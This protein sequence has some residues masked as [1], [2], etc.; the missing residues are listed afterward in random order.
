MAVGK[1]RR[2]RRGARVPE[3]VLTAALLLVGAGC[4]TRQPDSAFQ[5]LLKAEQGGSAQSSGAAGNASSAGNGTG[6]ANPSGAVSADNSSSGASAIGTGSLAGSGSAPV[7]G[8]GPSGSSTAPSSAN[9]SSSGAVRRGATDVGVSAD[10]ILVGNITSI[11]GPLGPDQFSPT[12]HGASAFFQALN[13]RGGI[14]GRK[15]KFL[16]CDDVENVDQDRQCAVN[17]IQNQKV[18]ALA[19]SNTRV[20]N[21]AASYVDSQGV[22]DVGSEAIGNAYAKYHH[23]YGIVGV[24]RYPRDGKQVGLNGNE[25]TLDGSYRWFKEKVGISRAAVFF[26]TIA[27]SRQAGLLEAA[28]LRRQG[29]SVVYY[30]GGS[31]QGENV[32]APSYDTDVINMRNDNVDTV[33]NT[34]D[35]GGFEKLCQAMDRYAF[36]VK[37][38]VSTIAGY[39]QLVG[40]AFSRPCR[41]SIYVVAT[42]RSYA[43]TANP[44]VAEVRATMQRYDPSYRLHQWVVEGFAG[45]RLF[46]DGVASLGA[47]VTRVGLERWL[48]GIRSYTAGDLLT[49]NDYQWPYDYGRPAPSCFNVAQWQDSAATFVTRSDTFTCY[50]MPWVAYQPQNDGS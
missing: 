36:T 26:Y 46:S 14:N 11:G 7:G 43:D 28:S 42:S 34:I 31:D 8:P 41:N 2:G 21:G 24:F 50:T 37:A 13:D 45:A 15:I 23:L 27:I 3:L 6:T 49:P 44:A 35:I 18:F 33:W 30:G 40:Q 4:G 29:V 48:N 38:N 9:A 39:G 16:T 17:L 47:N 19:A 22:P 12:Y 25:Y 20:Y 32:A 1:Q 10:T 5:A